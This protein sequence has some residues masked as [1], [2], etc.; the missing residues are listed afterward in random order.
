MQIERVLRQHSPDA[1]AASP[2]GDVVFIHRFGALLDA[3]LHYH[4]II[5]DGVFEANAQDSV[6]VH[7]ANGVDAPAIATVQATVRKRLLRAVQL[8]GLLSADD[9]LTMANHTNNTSAL[10]RSAG[11]S[12]ALRTPALTHLHI[13]CRQ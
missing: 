1:S 5:I 8:A 3:H 11:D 10:L 2:L 13:V 9:A 6:T 4:C 7:S 12:L